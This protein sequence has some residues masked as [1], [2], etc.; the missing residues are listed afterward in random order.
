MIVAEAQYSD[1]ENNDMVVSAE[2]NSMTAEPRRRV[3]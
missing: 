3:A 1:G 2:Y